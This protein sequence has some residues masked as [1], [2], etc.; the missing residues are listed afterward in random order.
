MT[1]S[2]EDTLYSSDAQF[3][4]LDNR[5]ALKADIPF[6]LDLASR[7][8]GDILELACGTG[9][10][11]IPLANAGHHTWG[12]EYSS[13]MVK[14][15]HLKLKELPNTTAER[16]HLFQGDMCAFNLE[17]KFPLILL[18]G[19][20]FQLLL[21]EPKENACLEC[22]NK[23]L[24]PGGHF[25]LAVANYSGQAG[26][27]WPNDNETFDWENIDPR[28]GFTIRRTH[29]KKKI[30]LEKQIL[31]PQ[32]NYYIT[33]NDGTQEKIIRQAAWKYFHEKQIKHLLENHGFK[34]I[35]QY[36]SFDG[37]PIGKGSEY[38]FLCQLY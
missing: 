12:L 7:L 13:A 35:N 33:K 16:I 15:F 30:D 6:Y 8:G 9:R 29:I 11:T 5:D 37:K 21:D 2:K 14:Q 17:R 26:P 18:P 31:F 1:E 19:R 25:L 28:T 3:Y 4:D 32:K 36:G 27:G 34:I 38:I 23:H 20:S 24:E 10:I 22:V